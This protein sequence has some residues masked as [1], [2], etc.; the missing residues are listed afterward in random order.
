MAP[1]KKII[2]KRVTFANA[3]GKNLVSVK[4]INKEGKSV[5][6]T[7]LE[8]KQTPAKLDTMHLKKL[9]A[10]AAAR[11]RLN[12]AKEK[13]A[14]VEKSNKNIKTME[15]EIAKKLKKTTKP[16]E[17]IALKAKQNRLDAAKKAINARRNEILVNYNLAKQKLRAQKKAG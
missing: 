14:I 3:S 6:L 13:I 17:I 15:K 8:R 16:V 4:Y 11:K 5:K 10:E 7:P 12:E 2:K 9:R 1:A